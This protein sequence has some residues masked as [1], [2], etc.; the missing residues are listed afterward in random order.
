MIE[1]KKDTFL[2]IFAGKSWQMNH[3][4]FDYVYPNAI[5]GWVSFTLFCS[6]RRTQI[7]STP[8]TKPTAGRPPPPPPLSTIATASDR[9]RYRDYHKH[10]KRYMFYRCACAAASIYYFLVGFM[11]SHMTSSCGSEEALCVSVR[12]CNWGVCAYE[13]G[14]IWIGSVCI[15]LHEEER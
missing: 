8:S 15:N 9:D 5:Y 2:N 3:C 12:G 1:E 13:S 14:Y 11:F 6:L 4:L 10:I 7:T